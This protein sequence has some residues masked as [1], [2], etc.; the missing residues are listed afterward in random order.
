MKIKKGKFDIILNTLCVIILISTA[1]FLIFYW[2]KIPDK[3]P[4]HHDF[5][6]NINRYGS[7]I[8]ILI[9][10]G[11]AWFMYFFITIIEHFPQIWNTGV[12]ITEE[13]KERVYC[14]L[15][16]L[17]SSMKFILVCVF[18][19][20]TFQTALVF[21]LSELFLPIFLLVTFINLF[22]WIWRLLKIR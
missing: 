15:L 5:S 14:T 8:E 17:V 22:Y 12:K 2:S 11:V 4:M 7:K 1:I 6:G 10:M 20:I 19:Y 9:L 21:K 3:V 18:T 13:N 16:H